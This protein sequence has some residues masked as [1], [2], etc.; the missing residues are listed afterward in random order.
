MYNSILLEL[1]YAGPIQYYTKLLTYNTV[2][3]EQMEN[4]SKGS[5]RNRMYI[6][7]ANGILCLSIPLV[8]GKHQ[9][10]DIRTVDIDYSQD[11]RQVHW[12]SI[13]TAYGSA[14]F[15]EYYAGPIIQ[16]YEKKY[17]KLF[18]LAIDFQ[19]MMLNFLKL[20]ANIEFT[21]TFERDPPEGVL[22]FRNQISPKYYQQAA[23]Y[24]ASFLPRPY[25]QL[26][27]DR[28]GFL[29]N[30]SILDLLFCTGPE[31]QRYLANSVKT[32]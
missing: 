5:F 26:F 24:D 10:A 21:S 20:T 2:F 31:A 3:L 30:L 15:F 6:A 27:E 14:P 16:F 9:Q 13:Q 23:L 28:Y 32:V 1:H 8:K 12:R 7:T 25:P 18:D 19:K 29:P 22:D 4:Y 11:W 17:E